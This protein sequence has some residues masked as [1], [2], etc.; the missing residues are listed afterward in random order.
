MLEALKQAIV[1]LGKNG[2]QSDKNI[3]LV[4]LLNASIRYLE[5]SA[6]S[7]SGPVQPAALATRSLFELNLITRY[8]LGSPNGMKRWYREYVRDYIEI[9]EGANE[10]NSPASRGEPRKV[11]ED[12]IKHLEALLENDKLPDEKRKQMSEIARVVGMESEYRAIYK[13][14][15]KLIH[16]SSILVNAHDYASHEAIADI[17]Q[18]HARHNAW[19]ICKL[20]STEASIPEG[21]VPTPEWVNF[22]YQ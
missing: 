14:C 15:S 12:D 4:N 2:E 22:I 21:A 9:L 7:V 17:L 11:F 18:M 5:I 13:L 16:P 19:T 20:I 6:R 3:L 1:W 8:M 10:I